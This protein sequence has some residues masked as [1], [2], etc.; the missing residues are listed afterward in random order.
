MERFDFRYPLALLLLI[1]YLFVVIIYIRGRINTRG[2]SFAL[3]SKH[4]IDVRK[5][6]RSAVYPYLPVLRFLSIF[7][8]IIALAE[9]GRSITYSGVKNTGI[10]IMIA[11]DL[12]SSMRGED[13]EPRN[14]LEVAKQVVKDFIAKRQNDRIGLAVFAGE[15]YLQ[16]PLTIEHDMLLDI[17]DEIDFDSIGVDGTAIGD[18]LALSASRMMDNTDGS[19]IILLITDGVSNRGSIDTETAAKACRELGIKVYSVG[20]GRDGSVPYP[21]PNG[22][23]GKRYVDNTFDASVLEKASEIT[24]GKFYRAESSG[25]FWEKVKE[26][27]RLEK[28]VYEVKKY[29]E[30]AGNFE[31]FIIAAMAFFFCELLLR[32]LVFRKLP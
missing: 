16:C 27:D 9:P 1:P 15:A 23:F 4:L 19:R 32:S 25:I 29:Y 13:F 31:V 18:A 6:W 10:D 24:N 17:V 14:R 12:S 7:L 20:I 30:F 26:I 8:L 11:L 5:T 28:H 2:A 22:F 21:D 3:S